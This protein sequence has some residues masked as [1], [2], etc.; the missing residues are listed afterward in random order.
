MKT[1]TL[2]AVGVF[3]LLLVGCGGGDSTSSPAP[4][5]TA[6][7]APAAHFEYE[8]AD[9]PEHWGEL[10][11]AYALCGTGM[12]QSPIDIVQPAG[13][14]LAN[15]AFHYQSSK[16]NILNNGHT[17]Q[18]NYDAGSYIE[19]DG[20]RY[21]LLQFHFHTPSEH[22]I[23]GHRAPLEVHFV[24]K[25][26]AGVLAVVGILIESGAENEALKTVFDN[27]PPMVAAVQTLNVSVNAADVL[28]STRT[29]YRYD[30]SLTTPPCSE[31][32][33]WNVLT[34]SIQVSPEQAEAFQSIFELD[35]RP[36]Q[37]LH[38]R[39]VVEDTTP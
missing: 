8:G 29:T 20:V 7:A 27:L 13:Q 14:N 1:M 37:P 35:S 3:A 24:H 30:G 22:T 39:S 32:V 4:S 18:V 2:V 5:P 26:S 9:G 16:V 15:I 28:P 31:G 38:G 34:E 11:P 23:D 21:D 6:T 33:K 10:S 25:S 12:K 36:V 19:I 17:V